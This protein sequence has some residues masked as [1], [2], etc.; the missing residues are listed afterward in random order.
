MQTPL[1]ECLL[2]RDLEH[3]ETG[4]KEVAAVLCPDFVPGLVSS[5]SSSYGEMSSRVP[6]CRAHHNGIV[7]KGDTTGVSFGAHGK[8]R[9]VY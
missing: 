3:H 5:Q 6:G 8:S 1:L 4:S 7:G 9:I 2:P